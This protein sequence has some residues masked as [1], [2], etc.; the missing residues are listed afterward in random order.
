MTTMFDS[1]IQ[2]EEDLLK[3]VG[4]RNKEYQTARAIAKAKYN[5]HNPFRRAL[6]D[7]HMRYVLLNSQSTWNVKLTQFSIL[8]IKPKNFLYSFD[9][10]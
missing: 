6:G 3:A 10:K 2:T 8:Y 9:Y 5:N 7:Y 4:R 1:Y